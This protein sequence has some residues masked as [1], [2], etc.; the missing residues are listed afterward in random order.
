MDTD[1][2]R[3]TVFSRKAA[4]GVNRQES[5]QLSLRLGALARGRPASSSLWNQIPKISTRKNADE[6]VGAGL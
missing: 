1:K 2:G 5:L 3:F 4:K 6:I